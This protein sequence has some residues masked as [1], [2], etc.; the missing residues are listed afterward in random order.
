MIHLILAILFSSGV[1]IAMRFFERHKFDNHQALTWNYFVATGLGLLMSPHIDTTRELVAEPWFELALLTGFWFIFTYLL[2]TYSS[3]RSGI[4]ITSLSSKLSVVIPSL[5]GII[6]LKERLGLLSAIGIVLALVALVLVISGKGTKET[7]GK[8][9]WVLPLLIF[10]GTGIGDILMK[11]TEQLNSSDSMTFM[12]T[13]IY[14][15]AMIFGFIIVAYDLITGKSKWQWRNILGGVELG[16][17]NFFSTTCI[18]RAMRVF[19]NV[20][21]FP[22][23]N[24]GVVSLTALIGWLFFKERLTWKNYLGLAI[25]IIAVILITL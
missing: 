9:G 4:T 10:F 11:S 14:F 25:A 24:I 21:L 17:F 5:F 2:M 3:Q 16:L 19:D 12:V 22:V 15:I 6:L 13:F 1:F 8:S 23:Y 18:Y 20:V 7:S